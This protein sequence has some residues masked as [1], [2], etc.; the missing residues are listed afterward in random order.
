MLHHHTP[1]GEAWPAGAISMASNF[2]ICACNACSRVTVGCRRNGR[3]LRA[4]TTSSLAYA[5]R[6]AVGPQRRVLVDVLQRQR[7]AGAPRNLQQQRPMPCRNAV[8]LP[9]ADGG[10]GLAKAPPQLSLPAEA[11][12]QVIDDASVL[13]SRSM[14]ENL[15]IWQAEDRVILPP[16]RDCLLSPKLLHKAVA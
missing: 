11:L 7:I 13:H 2:A 15:P 8:V 6:L 12:R 1:H 14:P 16:Q 3:G 4:T 9:V 10:V 5:R